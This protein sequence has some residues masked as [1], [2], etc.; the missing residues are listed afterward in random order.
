MKFYWIG[1]N[2]S[3]GSVQEQNAKQETP[4]VDKSQDSGTQSESPP[5]DSVSVETSSEKVLVEGPAEAPAQDTM[6]V[7]G[8][9]VEEHCDSERAGEEA[10]EGM[11][12]LEEELVSA[13]GDSPADCPQPSVEERRA[14]HWFSSQTQGVE[15]PSQS[16]EQDQPTQNQ[17]QAQPSQSPEVHQPEDTS[18]TLEAAQPSQTQEQAQ[19]S[20]IQEGEQPADSSQ[21]PEP[22][23]PS[24]TQEGEQPAELSQSETKSLLVNSSNGE[25]SSQGTVKPEEVVWKTNPIE[26]VESPDSF[27]SFLFWRDPLPEVDPD[28]DLEDLPP[29]QVPSSLHTADIQLL[30]RRLDEMHAQPQQQE[31]AEQPVT[32][33]ETRGKAELITTDLDADTDDLDILEDDN[34]LLYLSNSTEGLTEGGSTSIN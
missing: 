19:S 8:D 20:H 15:Q 34:I 21:T 4:A 32:A 18:Q 12:L 7:A 29:V 10:A 30:A 25:S 17:E 24:Q 31:A 22:A 9:G 33:V 14:Q 11:D 16:Q 1:F 6:P 27:T 26:N 13:Q 3:S 23:Q 2:F 28:E 5:T